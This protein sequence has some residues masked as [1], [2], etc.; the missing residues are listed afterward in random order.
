MT[1]IPVTVA[2]VLLAIVGVTGCEQLEK[3]SDTIDRNA[4]QIV[5]TVETMGPAIGAA[6]APYTG[7]VSALVAGI[8]GAVVP[9]LLAANRAVVAHRRKQALQEVDKATNSPPLGEQLTA[10][11]RKAKIAGIAAID[12]R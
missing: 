12:D 11:P 5:E 6:A 7:G 9:G 8:I 3:A 4:D 1:R 2:A 10:A